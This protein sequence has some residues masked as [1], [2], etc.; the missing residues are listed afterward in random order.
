VNDD[1][2]VEDVGGLIVMIAMAL[3]ALFCPNWWRIG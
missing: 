2:W 3:Y 1:D